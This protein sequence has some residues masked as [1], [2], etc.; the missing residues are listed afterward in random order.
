MPKVL[1]IDDDPTF[2]LMLK[3]FLNKNSFET[4]E[5]HNARES[6]KIVKQEPFDIILTDFRLPDKNGLD[7]LKDIKGII[8]KTPVILMTSYANIRTAVNAIKMGAYEYVTKPINAD[9]VLAAINNA[10]DSA[11]D[12][13]IQSDGGEISKKDVKGFQFIKGNS[14]RFKKI[15]QHIEL[16]APTNMSILIHGESGTGKEYV[17]RLIHEK[18]KRKDRPF[19]AIDCGA[20]SDELAASELFGHIKGSFTGAVTDKKGQF[21]VAN[22]GTLF[23]DE[24]GNLSY[25]IQVKLLRATQEKKIRKVGGNTDIEVNVRLIAATNEDLQKAVNRGDFREDLYHRI[26]EFQ[27]KVPPLRERK[28]DISIFANHFLEVSN[29][30][31]E[32]N[33]QTIEHDVIDKFNNYSWPGNIRELKNVVKRSVLLEQSDLLTSENLPD[34]IKFPSTDHDLGTDDT[35]TDGKAL[36][37]VTEKKEKEMILRTLEQVKY[38]KSKAARILNIDRKT[39]Y[40]K[41]KQYDIEA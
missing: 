13:K 19:V 26:N 9:E 5:V 35:E 4:K 7:L 27:I 28:G 22:G 12:K 2:C 16:V 34:E 17:S 38:N 39:L 37:E 25:E 18:S 40:N 10:L 33:I 36:R 21:E 20:L 1:I 15:H 31:L 29:K 32:R 11:E 23:L 14:E 41:L 3:S 30:E 8:P 24:I 6:I